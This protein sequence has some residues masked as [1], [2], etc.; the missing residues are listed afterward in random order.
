M[1]VTVPAETISFTSFM[2]FMV[3]NFSRIRYAAETV[4]AHSS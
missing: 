4:E 2:L 3:K 1:R